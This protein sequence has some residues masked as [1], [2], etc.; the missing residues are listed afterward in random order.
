MGRSARPTFSKHYSSIVK[1]ESHIIKNEEIYSTYY[2]YVHVKSNFFLNRVQL[3]SSDLI[4]H[5]MRFLLLNDH[6]F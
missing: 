6:T 1:L 3:N 5:I 4:G 2:L